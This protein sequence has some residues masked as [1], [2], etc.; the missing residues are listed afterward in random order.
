MGQPVTGVLD[1]V[2]GMNEVS[3]YQQ[4][5]GVAR[6]HC[7]EAA[8]TAVELHRKD[9]IRVNNPGGLRLVGKG[10]YSDAMIQAASSDVAA[11]GTERHRI[12]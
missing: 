9:L 1:N 12:N 6:G 3:A 2:C 7:Y 8:I 11:V 10:Q 5:A 4:E